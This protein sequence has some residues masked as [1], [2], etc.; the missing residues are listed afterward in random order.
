MSPARRLA[1][2]T[3]GG[4]ALLAFGA[5]TT[6]PMTPVPMTLQTLALCWVALAAGW[7]AGLGAALF[8][9]AAV[10]VGLPVLADGSSAP[11][12]TFFIELKSAGYV[13][14]FVPGALLAG[15]LRKN[16]ALRLL[17]GVLAHAVVLLVGWLVLST[18]IGA[19]PAWTHG[20]WPF[21]VGGLVKT[22]LAAVMA[23][24][25]VAESPS[26]ST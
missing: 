18:H 16:L 4:A 22:V 21:V 1:L 9:L 7:R 5:Q 25:F 13:L 8:Y 14:G 23:G 26:A 3:V 10:L 11:G 19:G 24:P 2:W 6:V 15:L 12:A 17:G 20:V